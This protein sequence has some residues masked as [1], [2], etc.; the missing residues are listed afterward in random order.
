MKQVA[1]RKNEPPSSTSGLG[2]D[3]IQITL[4]GE[5]LSVTIGPV[6][7]VLDRVT[8]EEMTYRLADALLPFDSLNV[9]W[10]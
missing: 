8:A 7:L 1:T 2:K 6:T 5:R 3:R 4:L 10:N 9:E